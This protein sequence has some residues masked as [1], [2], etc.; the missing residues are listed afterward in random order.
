MIT[1]KEKYEVKI[2]NVPMGGNNPIRVQSMTNTDTANPEETA[3][4]TIDLYEAGSEYVRFTVKDDEGAKAVPKLR[5]IL[6]KQGYDIPLIGDFHYNGHI[7]LTKYPDMAQTLDKYRINPGNV[8]FG[9][10]QDKNYQTMVESA[11]DHKKP[12]RIGV[13]WGSIDQQIVKKLMEE[14]N[15]KADKDKKN[16]EQLLVEALVTSAI[17]SA[18][19]AEKIGLKKDKIVLSTKVSKVPQLLEAYEQLSNQ[20]KYALHVGLTE[21]GMGEK[22]I[23]GSTAG[24]STLL[25]QGI[26]DTIRV[27]I[28]PEPGSARTKEVEISQ[29]ILQQNGLRK[30]MP[31]V[32][33]CPG[34]GRTTSTIF[35]EMAKDITIYLHEQTPKWK[36]QGY[37]GVEGMI[38]AVMGC[39]VNGPGESK[40]ANIGISLP[41]SGEDPSC[42]VY[43]DGKLTT[44]IKGN[45]RTK[46]FRQKID[47]YV[48]S[49]YA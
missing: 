26:G 21:A 48:K 37:N 35:Q 2:G 13:N 3:K 9:E 20:T 49:H 42:P 10:A 43:E 45:N 8:G 15:K 46:E 7:L 24:I 17:Q 27:S 38:V 18:K 23:I 33:S 12:V 30:F 47:D 19:A 22:G 14:N 28:T 16:S 1:R 5:D 40:D 25:Q 39:I 32:T 29:Q 6:E 44:T 34:C 36:K 41:G 11:I 31:T 4:Q